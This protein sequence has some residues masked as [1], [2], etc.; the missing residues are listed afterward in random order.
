MAG[1]T[2]EAGTAMTDEML[3]NIAEFAE[4]VGIT[5]GS[6]YHFVS[7]KRVPVVR[8]SPRCI[9]FRPSAIAAWVESK[10]IKGEK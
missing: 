3:W 10:S 2:S 8:I 7:Q 6:A 1:S 4:F 9:R 5:V